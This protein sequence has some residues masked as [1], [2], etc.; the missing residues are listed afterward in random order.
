MEERIVVADPVAQ[1]QEYQREILALLGGRDPVEV[2]SGTP[3]AFTALTAGLSRGALVRPPAPGEWSVTELLGHLFDAEVA[4]S[5]RARTILA[6]DGGTPDGPPLPGFDQTTWALLPRPPFGEFLA[7]F[8]ALRAANLALIAG[9]PE[10]HWAR[11]GVH[12]E[13]GPL[14]FRVLTETAAGH[15]IA[16]RRQL[17][18]TVAAVTR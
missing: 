10:P 1:P 5:W 18:Q 15:D 12:A 14:S 11:S 16:H 4:W 17:E 3:A 13:R 2:L 9:T 6:Q 7:A 8:G